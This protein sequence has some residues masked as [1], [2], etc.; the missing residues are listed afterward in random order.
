MTSND[1]TQDLTYEHCIE[2]M[3]EWRGLDLRISVLTGGITNK[4]YR[5]QL[6]DGGDYVVRVYGEKTDLF[7]DRDTEA[8][9]IR[10][11]GPVGVAPKLVKYLREKNVTIVEFIPGTVLKNGDFLK[12]DLLKLLVRPIKRIHSCSV[13]LSR[14][15]EPFAEVAR[16][17]EVLTQVGTVYPEFD[18]RGTVET[19]GRIWAV[20]NI[21]L[22]DFLPCH[23]DLLADNF[24]MVEGR[25]RY[26]ESI[27]LIDWEY[28]GMNTP[29]YEFGDMFQEIRVPRQVE[30]KIL[31]IYWEDHNMDEHIRKTD[32][33]K[34]FPDIYWFLWSLIQLNISSIDFDYYNYGRVKYQNAQ[35]TIRML[36]HRYGLNV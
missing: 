15:F 4:L 11:L 33:L 34:P 2:L 19:L 24:V 29:Y 32:M 31:R 9:T 30:E 27:Y 8:D 21:S 3:P 17:F 7:I 13:E 35:E 12:D 10:R 18:I 25:G 36:R 20:V 1:M 14:T 28:A 22:S 6:P 23:N 16:L 5:V 26:P